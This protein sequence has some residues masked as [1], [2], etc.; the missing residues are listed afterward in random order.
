[1]AMLHLDHVNE[2]RERHEVCGTTG[3]RCFRTEMGAIIEGS[4]TVGRA[5]GAEVCPY[6]G[7]WHW[8]F[9][10]GPGVRVKVPGHRHD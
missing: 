4:R 9:R 6:C 10:L 8:L 5:V 1:M 3:F 2:V 7:S